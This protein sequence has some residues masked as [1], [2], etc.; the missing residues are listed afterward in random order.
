MSRRTLAGVLLAAVVF[1]GCG[2]SG[3]DASK[4][5]AA[6]AGPRLT[7]RMARQLDARFRDTVA[8]AGIPGASAAIVFPDGRVWTGAAG[9][10]VV[11]PKRG[12]TT[13]TALPFDSVTKLAT[14]ALTM[15][16]VEQGRLR[17]DDPIGRWYPAWRGDPH[18]TVRDLLGHTSGVRDAYEADIV[19]LVRHRRARVSPQQYLAATPEPLPRTPVAEYS[20]AGF[21]ILGLII[22]RITGEPVHKAM[23][24]ELFG[25]PG[26]DGLALQPG[27]VAHEPRA[28]SYYYPRGGAVPVDASD[29]GPV[30][31]FRALAGAAGTAGALAGDVPSLARWGHELFSGRVIQPRSLREMARFHLG[32]FWE[33]YGLGLARD[34][35]DG[36]TMWGHGGDGLGS[37]TEFWHLPR[38]RLTIAVTW[39]DD[40]LD[41]DGQIFPQLLRTALGSLDG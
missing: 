21:V 13:D 39:N 11:K 18:A 10:A 9:R 40:L 30:I 32:A 20:N 7:D 36:H 5:A 1:A 27:E 16:L 17:L 2:G 22:E 6:K 8:G 19:T 26:G 34:S 3:D 14:S 35:L 28:H 33:A 12:M 25:H 41:R 38:D 24:R 29:G 31:P 23:R 15:R 4:G 37:H